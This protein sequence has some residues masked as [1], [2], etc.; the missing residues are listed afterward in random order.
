M[1]KLL[2]IALLPSL[3]IQGYAVKKNTP[4]LPEAM[5]LRSGVTETGRSK[6]SIL[7]VGDSAAAGVGVLNQEDAL[8]GQLLAQLI[9]QFTIDYQLEAKTGD[10]TL[11]LFDRIQSLPDKKF[12]VVISSIGVNDVTKLVSPRKWLKQQQMLYQ[13]IER[14]FKPQQV[15]IKELPAMNHFPAL[16]NPLAWLFGQYASAMNT[17]LEKWI[18]SKP[19]YQLIQFDIT[20]FQALALPMASDGFHPSKQIYQYWAERIVEG[21][22]KKFK[23][24]T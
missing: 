4:R 18:Q 6:L 21:V 1:L 17:L 23:S 3:F 15:L 2:T 5:G 7:I 22:Q 8:L 9:P 14:K 13:E 12:D 16:P 19:H 10:T 20:Q 24:S 11:Q